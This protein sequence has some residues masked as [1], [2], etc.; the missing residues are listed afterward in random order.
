MSPKF[1]KIYRAYGQRFLWTF[2]NRLHV[3]GSRRRII[4]KLD[5]L[6][7]FCILLDPRKGPWIRLL[8][9]YLLCITKAVILFLIYSFTLLITA[10]CADTE[11]DSC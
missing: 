5:T 6:F 7:N 10:V 4:L 11:R 2:N 8:Q 1:N 9:F 3:L